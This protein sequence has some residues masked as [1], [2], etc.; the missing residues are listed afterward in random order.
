MRR[1]I[2]AMILALVMI[3]SLPLSVSAEQKE[4]DKLVSFSIDVP[5]QYPITPA[6]EEWTNFKT[7]KEM[8]DSCQIPNHVLTRMTTN[9]LLET[10]LNYPFLGTYKCYDDYEIAARYLC[11][12][13]N[14]LEELFSRSDLTEILLERY[15]K[16]K[17]LTQKDLNENTHLRLGYI[18]TFFESNNLEFLIAYDQSKNG[19]YSE[20][21]KEKFSTLYS[22]KV[23]LRKDQSNI[24][25]N[26]GGTYTSFGAQVS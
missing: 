6:D 11:E 10:V 2:F 18:N 9:A 13:F 7:S 23:Q 12:Q 22:E 26:T 24:Y 8:Y 4:H 5:Y 1:R 3:L 19:Q 17:V 21:E 25:S 16:S 14:G 20:E 15:A